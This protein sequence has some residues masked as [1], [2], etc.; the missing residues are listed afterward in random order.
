MLRGARPG[1]GFH[2]RERQAAGLP[3]SGLRLTPRPTGATPAP[4]A[5]TVRQFMCPRSDHNKVWRVRRSPRGW[6]IRPS[7][8][9]S[10]IPDDLAVR[11]GCGLVRVLKR[12]ARCALRGD[13]ALDLGFL[14]QVFPIGRDRAWGE[15]PACF[16]LV[17]RKLLFRHDTLP[18]HR[19]ASTLA[20]ASERTYDV[21]HTPLRPAFTCAV[22]FARHGWI[23]VRRVARRG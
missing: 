19:T 1:P 8:R 12:E 6:N 17:M 2:Q 9:Q 14:P 22:W 16:R 20:R 13:P 21:G 11:T 7:L 15:D 10:W 5:D 18:R 4:T 3:A 23:P